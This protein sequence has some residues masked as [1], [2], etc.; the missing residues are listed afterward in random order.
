MRTGEAVADPGDRKENRLLAA[1]CYISLLFLLGFWLGRDSR[2]AQH[3]ARQGLLL[4]A[5]AVSLQLLLLAAPPALA[6]AS[7]LI[8]VVW[9]VSIVYGVR[10]AWLGKLTP[11]PLLGRLW[12]RA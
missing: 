8:S 10:Q 12:V 3:H 5:A 2:L 7:E 6:R 11:L 1:S 4:Y 9:A